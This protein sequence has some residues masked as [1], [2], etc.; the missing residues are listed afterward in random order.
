MAEANPH[1]P[2]VGMIALLKGPPLSVVQLLLAHGPQVIVTV[3]SA[4]TA[5]SRSR[6][7]VSVIIEV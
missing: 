1:N 6:M 3:V 5:V 2:D 4:L 7:D